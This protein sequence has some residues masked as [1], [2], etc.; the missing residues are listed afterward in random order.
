MHAAVCSARSSVVKLLQ[1]SSVKSGENGAAAACITGKLQLEQ[2]L[3]SLLK[4][5]SRTDK[6][7][8]TDMIFSM[9]HLIA[10]EQRR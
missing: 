9:Y 5:G 6:S 4:L 10:K 3:G 1:Q 7:P 2:R 8:S